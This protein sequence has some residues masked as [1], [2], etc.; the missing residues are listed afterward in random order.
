MREHIPMNSTAKLGSNWPSGLTENFF[1]C[2]EGYNLNNRRS[3]TG[4]ELQS[5]DVFGKNLAT[6]DLFQKY[7]R[8]DTCD[9]PYKFDI[10]DEVRF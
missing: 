5:F 9:K 3:P 2:C 1:K 10:F 8:K 7:D 6:S 4:D